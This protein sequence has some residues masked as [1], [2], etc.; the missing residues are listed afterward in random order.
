MSE[1]KK[2]SGVGRK[3]NFG[4]LIYP[5]SAPTNW[6]EL[7]SDTHIPAFVSPL[8]DKDVNADGT[9]KKAHYHVMLMY[10]GVKTDKQVEEVKNLLGGVGNEI[11]HSLRGYARYLTH[12][13]NPEK[14][15]YNDK[16]ILSFSGANYREVVMLPTDAD[17][18]VS[19][20]TL[21][22]DKYFIYSFRQFFNYCRDNKEDWYYALL[23]GQ[24][25]VIK[26][27]I[28]SLAWEEASGEAK[29]LEQLRAEKL[30]DG[31]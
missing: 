19:E 18:I 15:Q 22:I 2:T 9:I 13:D 27:Y 30:K 6:K 11:I 28:K 3:R 20:M 16:D 8:H 23:H 7:L 26:E 21:Y 14:A 1:K 24:S 5:D 10:E 29:I 31:I 17:A 4:F 12:K 25:Y